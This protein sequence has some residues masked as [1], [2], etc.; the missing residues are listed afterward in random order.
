METEYQ[1]LKNGAHKPITDDFQ[2]IPRKKYN[3]LLKS[4]K[5]NDTL[6]RA[7]IRD[8]FWWGDFFA[9]S[10]EGVNQKT[11]KRI[12]DKVYKRDFYTTA[13]RLP[14]KQNKINIKNPSE[15]F[16]NLSLANVRGDYFEIYGF[17]SECLLHVSY[18]IKNGKYKLEQDNFAPITRREY[19]SFLQH[20]SPFLVSEDIRA[21]ERRELI[22]GLGLQKESFIEKEIGWKPFYSVASRI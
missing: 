8:D 13:S 2:K 17:N 9:N 14:N 20:N 11:S 4:L 10:T 16:E 18:K 19:R 21:R 12:Y 7:S 3:K 5:E 22:M 1:V 15:F 6:L